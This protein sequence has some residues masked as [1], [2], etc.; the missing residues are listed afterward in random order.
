MCL[1]QIGRSFRS[2]TFTL[3]EIDQELGDGKIFEFYEVFKTCDAEAS[4]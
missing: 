1:M 2:F 3:L 4:T